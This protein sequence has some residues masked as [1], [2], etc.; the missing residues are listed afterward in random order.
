MN[1][2]WKKRV[3][4]FEENPFALIF[5]NNYFLVCFGTITT[6]TVKTMLKSDQAYGGSKDFRLSF[7]KLRNLR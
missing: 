6:T 3:K 7:I 2:C 5:I 4:F 1:A